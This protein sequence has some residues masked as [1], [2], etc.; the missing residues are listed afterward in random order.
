M[1][2]S[3]SRAN[4]F[5]Y[6]GLRRIGRLTLRIAK[7]V[8]RRAILRAD[9]IALAHALRRV[10]ISPERLQQLL[11]RDSSDR[12]ARLLFAVSVTRF[13]EQEVGQRLAFLLGKL[14]QLRDNQLVLG[15][16]D[17]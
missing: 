13:A 10:V 16:Y 14:S 2:P 12:M 17:P 15:V 3:P 11:V 7:G 4:T 1:A 8:D 9:I 5:W 6:Y